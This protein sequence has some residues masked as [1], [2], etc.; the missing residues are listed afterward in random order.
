MNPLLGWTLAALAMASGYVGYGAAGLVLALTVVAF[1]LLLQFSRALR[2]M[3]RAAGHALGRTDNAV[4]LYARLRPG[5]TLLRIVALTR[6]LGEKLGDEPECWC[7]RD[8]AGDAV[9]VELHKGRASDMRLER[10][11]VPAPRAET[12]DGEQAAEHQRVGGGLGHG[13]HG[14]QEQ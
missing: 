9:C 13:G 7:W 14:G 5:M 2:V 8:D 4:M 11:R 3:R 10:M 12:G 6:S 1:W